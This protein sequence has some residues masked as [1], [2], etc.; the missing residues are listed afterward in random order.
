VLTELVDQD[1]PVQ[2]DSNSGRSAAGTVLSA[3]SDQEEQRT[4]GRA[5]QMVKR[6][7]YVSDP[8]TH[9][10]LQPAHHSASLVYHLVIHMVSGSRSRGSLRDSKNLQQHRGESEK[11]EYQSA[12]I[13]V[14][15]HVHTTTHAWILFT[16]Q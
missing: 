9:T 3:K 12:A 16:Y 4:L 7:T 5:R 15:I 1:V 11:R 6:G 13:H 10:C 8:S 2:E 14:S